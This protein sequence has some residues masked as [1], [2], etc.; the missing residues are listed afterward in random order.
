ML[1]SHFLQSVLSFLL[2]ST[3]SAASAVPYPRSGSS[4][5]RTVYFELDLTWGPISPDGHT[6]NGI[7]MNGQFPGPLL[8]LCD[9]DSVEFLVHNN[10]PFEETIHFHGI[11]QKGSPWSDGVP[12]L[13][14]RGIK[15]GESFLYKWTAVDQY[16]TYW[17]HSHDRN[18]ILDGLYGPILIH[19]KPDEPTP[20]R[21]ISKDAKQVF[22]MQEAEYNPKL[23]LISD[24]SHF[25]SDQ[26]FG[27]ETSVGID[28]FCVDS[29][30]INGKGS[31][32]CLPQSEINALT[33]PLFTSMNVTLT[34]KGCIPATLPLAQGDFPHDFSKLPPT[35]FDVCEPSTGPHE[36]IEV[37]AADEWV[38]ID[39]ISTSGINVFTA[40]ID[41][42]PMWIYSVDGR[43]ITPVLIDA[44][45]IANGNRYS[46]MVKL[47]K[48]PGDYTIRMANPGI[49][50][51]ISGFATLRY[52]GS[53]NT[54]K[55]TPFINYAAVNTTP[56]VIMFD[57]TTIKPF[58]PT[59]PN[60]TADRTFHL[61]INRTGA[62]WEW[63][64][65]GKESF[66]L[67]LED[68]TPLLFDPNSSLGKNKNLTI[69]TKMGEW[70]D[71]IVQVTFP[72]QPP[73]P[74]HKHSNKGYLIGQGIGAFNWSTTAEALKEIPQSFNLNDPPFRDGYTTLPTSTEPSW[75]VLRYHVENP[76][77]FLFHCH[78]QTHLGGGMAVA[79]L[80]GIDEFPKVPSEY[81]HG[82]GITG[83]HGYGYGSKKQHHY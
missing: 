17:Y 31:E 42:H 15:S 54:F 80:D 32:Y 69:T 11:E 1:S 66:G 67:N 70:V 14:Q 38:S 5:P 27:I 43:H 22:R 23:V 64:L 19:P 2:V 74:L 13:S 71:I 12:G 46:A 52:K 41:E 39:F 7:L 77:A 62:T 81:L 51:L 48:K 72:L 79:I 59:K 10:L 3:L 26:F 82:N 44:I 68:V 53:K 50:Q 60:P 56:S 6:R 36:I 61:L 76:G 47:D 18:H 29:V 57:E 73:H 65:S 33:N 25:T 21:T 34:A 4:K 28:N 35:A 63:T 75:T 83:G 30:L 58:P 9:G 78:I 37:D 8:E 55:S 49:N 45:T 16:G 40:A 24:W 20:L